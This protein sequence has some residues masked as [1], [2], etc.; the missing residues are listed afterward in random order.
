MPIEIKVTEDGVGVE[1]IVSGVLTGAEIIEAN[2]QIYGDS[3]F[4]NLKYQLLDRTACTDF[5]VSSDEVQDIA[6]QEIAAARTNPEMVVAFVSTSDLQYG[7]SRMYQAYVDD[8]GFETELFRDRQSAQ[9]WINA[10]VN[11]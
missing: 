9:E 2:K 5:Q 8:K 6:E 10:R 1:F 11:D 3:N 4:T 7:V